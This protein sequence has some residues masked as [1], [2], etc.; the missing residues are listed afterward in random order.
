MHPSYVK[1]F[2]YYV[3][4]DNTEDWFFDNALQKCTLC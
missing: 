1:M 4:L 3:L 2:Q